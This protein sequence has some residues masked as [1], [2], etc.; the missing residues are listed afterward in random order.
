MKTN[1]VFK[2]LVMSSMINIWDVLILLGV[3][4]IGDFVLQPDYL[5]KN[6]SHSW[7]ALL[8]HTAIYSSV[9]S[10]IMCGLSSTYN[11][12]MFLWF[13]PITFVFHT[14]TDYYT[15]RVNAQLYKEGKNHSFFVSI[16]F[17]QLLHFAQI[18]LT[19]QLLK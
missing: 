5:A 13:I 8:E 3:H 9:F 2:K 12:W 17:D 15:S 10:P 18:L 4:W 11:N 7:K 1:P 14:F 19:Y 16:G 6:K